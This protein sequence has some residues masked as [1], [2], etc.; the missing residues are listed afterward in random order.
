MTDDQVAGD[1]ADVRL[2]LDAYRAFQA[3]DIDRATASLHQDVVWI[4]PDEFPDG[5][6]YVGPASVADYLSRSRDRWRTV[7]STPLARRVGDKIAVRHHLE[8][9]AIDGTHAEATVADVFTV[10]DGVIVHM[11]A[12]ADPDCAF[13]L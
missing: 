1:D 2:I 3:G 4:E 8:G 12:Y 6:R 11:Q 10:R 9:Q 13:T 7:V 5:G